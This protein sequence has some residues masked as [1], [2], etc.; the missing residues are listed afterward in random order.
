VKRIIV[1]GGLGQ[2]GRTAA[3]EL[4]ALELPF[5]TASRRGAAEIH[6]D[7]NDA[8]SIRAV[9]QS[10][11]IV[12][13]TAGPFHSRSTA[14]LESAIQIGFDVIDINDDL[15]YAESVLALAPRIDSAGIRVLSSASS[16]S[17]IAAAVV[18]QSGIIEPRRVTA[19]LAP[20][21]RHTS[22]PCAALSLIRAVGRPVRIFHD[23]QLQERI[24]WSDSK[25]FRM[26]PPLGTIHGRLFESA[27]A[28]LLPRIWPTLRDVAMYVDT[29]TPGVNNLLRLAARYRFV[30]RVLEYRAGLGTRIARTLGSN[31]GGIG[32]EIEDARGHIARYAIVAAK[33]SF[34]TAVAPAVLAAQALAEDGFPHRGLVAADRHVDPDVLFAFLQSRGIIIQSLE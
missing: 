27:D 34:I 17:A 10:G 9:I 14:L 26:P 31:A 19:F 25:S 2:F 5:V 15:R 23:G 21:S 22:N 20:A 28:A 24:G 7:A 32:Y 4:R 12:L 29:N 18:R 8:S 16:V 33:N 13:D 11:D 3:N 30:R 1:L 6:V